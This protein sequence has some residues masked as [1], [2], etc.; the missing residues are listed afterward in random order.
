MDDLTREEIQEFHDRGE[1]V[2]DNL[3]EQLHDD[4]DVDN[5]LEMAFQNY[6]ATRGK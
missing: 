1:T 5:E 2:P 6:L 4:T 3:V